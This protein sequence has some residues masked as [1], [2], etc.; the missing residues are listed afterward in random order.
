MVTHCRLGADE[1]KSTSWI[2]E[3]EI[4]SVNVWLGG[5]GRGRSL[6]RQY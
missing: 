3:M 1:N 5:C 6:K 4:D 2:S